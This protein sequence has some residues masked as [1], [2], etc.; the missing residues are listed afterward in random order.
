MSAPRSDYVTDT[1]TLRRLPGKPLTRMNDR[2]L[3]DHAAA[4]RIGHQHFTDAN[5]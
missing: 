1:I 5:A 3:M 4:E 2:R